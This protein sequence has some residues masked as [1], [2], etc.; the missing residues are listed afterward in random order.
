MTTRGKVINLVLV[1][2]L[3]V[4]LI[5][6]FRSCYLSDGDIDPDQV[7][8]EPAVLHAISGNTLVP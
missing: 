2:A 5:A 1:A 3:V 6:F 8:G 4:L 7:Q